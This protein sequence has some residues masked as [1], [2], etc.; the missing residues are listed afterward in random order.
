LSGVLCDVW[1]FTEFPSQPSPNRI[2]D[3][4]A[5]NAVDPVSANACRSAED[6]EGPIIQGANGVDLVFNINRDIEDW[7]IGGRLLALGGGEYLGRDVAVAEV[8]D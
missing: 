2:N 8:D 4:L 5:G 3:L 6:D 1:N 7:W